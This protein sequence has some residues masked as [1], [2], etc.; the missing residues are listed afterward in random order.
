MKRVRLPSPFWAFLYRRK[1]IRAPMPFWRVVVEGRPKPGAR[2]WPADLGAV[3]GAV[4]VWARTIEE[5]EGLAQL[6]V[7]AEG[8]EPITADAVKT[9]PAAR[10]RAAPGSAG[11]GEWGF[12]SRGGETPASR[13]GERA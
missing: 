9:A 5:A 4:F 1:L 6:A 11:A 3:V 8:F 2:D 10:P 7:E 12:L 13:R